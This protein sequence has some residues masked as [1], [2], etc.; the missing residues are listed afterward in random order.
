MSR[1]MIDYQVEGN[2][3]STID[4]YKVGGDELTGAAIM[5]VSKDSNTITRTL[6]VD[7]KVKFDA[8]GG[9]KIGSYGNAY[10]VLKIPARSWEANV[11]VDFK[12][13]INYYEPG[14]GDGISGM[15]PSVYTNIYK[16]EGITFLVHTH[17]ITERNGNTYSAHVIVVPLSAGTTTKP[18]DVFAG[19]YYFKKA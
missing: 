9:V 8:K 13:S 5:G 4:G 1:K 12:D 18:F 10:S 14:F 19:F 2:K 17:S 3:I 16:S 6:D 11:P 7:G 15:Y